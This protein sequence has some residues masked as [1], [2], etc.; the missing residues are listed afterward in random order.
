M[1]LLPIALV[2]LLVP[3][4]AQAKPIRLGAVFST[5][6]AAAAYGASQVQGA[7]LAVADVNRAGTL[8]RRL[9]V[10]MLDDG[11]DPA[12]ATAA[13]GTLIDGGAAALLGPTLSGAALQADVLAQQRRVPVMGVSN[14]IDGITEIGRY[15]FRD[16]LPESTVQ[17]LTLARVHAKLG[18]VRVAIV[19]ATPDAYSQAAH[20]VFLGALGQQGYTLAADVSFPSADPDAHRAAV[21][22]AAAAHPDSLIIAAL[23]PDVARV[24]TYA[25]TL[26]ALAGVPF[27]GGNSFNTPGLAAQAGAAAEGAVAGAAWIASRRTPGNRAFVKAF[28][29]RYGHAPDQFAAQAYAGVRLIAAAIG[30]RGASRDAIRRGLAGLRKVPSVLGTF[31][32]TAGREPVYD[33][34]VVRIA[35]NGFALL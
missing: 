10:R 26:P 35:G 22:Q 28:T 24:M 33:P 30:R 11:S 9:T 19:W 29:A 3:A 32:F 31:S 20:D 13:F 14:T 7:R 34:V 18:S 15:V 27:I 25:R 8:E 21:D 5:S 17:P 1:R 6:G 2:L 23:A 4:G 12:R 16:S